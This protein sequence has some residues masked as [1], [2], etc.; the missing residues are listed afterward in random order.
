MKNRGHTGVISQ[1]KD[2]WTFI[3]SGKMDNNLSG[4]N[5]KKAVGEENLKAELLNWF[6]LVNE[7][8]SALQI[9]LGSLDMNRLSMFKPSQFRQKA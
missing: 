9:T 5:G 6:K 8:K 3:N 7:E 1:V 2:Q 4:E